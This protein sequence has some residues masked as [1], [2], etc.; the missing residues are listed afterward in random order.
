MKT[1]YYCIGYVKTNLLTLLIGKMLVIKNYWV[2]NL[3]RNVSNMLPNYGISGILRWKSIIEI[4]DK[5]SVSDC[6]Q[7]VR[8]DT[9][10]VQL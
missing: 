7:A 1:K 5:I 9:F 3:L 10:E 6:V 8:T 2:K 4:T